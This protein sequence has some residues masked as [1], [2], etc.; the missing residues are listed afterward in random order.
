MKEQTSYS[1][2][3]KRAIVIL[4][5]LLLLLAFFGSFFFIRGRI[6]AN[7]ADQSGISDN[8]NGEINSDDNNNS[9]DNNTNTNGQ[10]PVVDTNQSSS[11]N[12]SE[13]IR[14]NNSNS[15]ANGNQNT[16]SNVV[17][18]DTTAPEI[19]GIENGKYYAGKVTATINADDLASAKCKFEAE[20]GT[21]TEF[22]FTTGH[23]FTESGKYTLTVKDESGKTTELTFTIDLNNPN[24]KINDTIYE[25]GTETIYANDTE[26]KIENTDKNADKA[27]LDDEELSDEIIELT[28]GTHT[29]KLTDKAG[30]ETVYTLVVDRTAPVLTWKDVEYTDGSTIYANETFVVNATDANEIAEVAPN[31]HIRYNGWRANGEGKYTIKVTDVAGNVATFTVIVDKTAPTLNLNGTS[32]TDSSKTIYS[33]ATEFTA[34]VEDVNADKVY[35]NDEEKTGTFTLEEGTYSVKVTDLAGNETVYTLVV[36]R[37]APVYTTLG[38]LNISNYNVDGK[39]IAYAKDGEKVRV[40]VSFAEKL[41]KEPIVQIGEKEYTATY[42][43]ASSNAD[44]NIYYYMAD[45]EVTTE[46][47]EG[48]LQFK[49]KDFADITGNVGEVL[50]NSN[51]NRSEYSKVIIDRTVPTLKLNGTNYTDSSKTIYSNATEFTAEVEDTNADKVYVN[52]EEK[53]GTFTLEE[54]TYSIK[55]TD[56]AGNENVYTLVVDRTNPTLKLNGTSYTDS[57]KTI[58]SNATEFTAEVEDVNADKV[59]VNDEEKT[60]PFT[61]EEGTYTVKVTDLAENETV[62]TLVVDRTAPVLTLCKFEKEYTGRTEL[63]TDKI[64]N[65]SLAVV[66]DEINLDTAK[67]EADDNTVVDYVSKTEIGARKDYTL[68]VTDL[69]GNVSTISFGID[70]DAP[71]IEGVENG[72]Y[73]NVDVAPVVTDK[74]LDKVT[75]TFNDAENDF[76]EGTVFTAEGKYTITAVDKAGNKTTKTFYIDKTAPVLEIK[77]DSIGTDPYY[78]RISFKLR[79]NMKFSNYYTINGTKMTVTPAQWGDADFTTLRSHLHQGENTIELIDMAGNKTTKTFVYDT[80][81]PVLT[82]CKFEKE[83]TGNTKIE[84]D[85]IYNYSVAVAIEEVNPYTAKLAGDDNSVVDYVS[86]TEIGARKDY[87]LTVTDLAGNVSTISF[88]ID[89]DAPKIESVEN[90]KYYNVDVAPVVTDK[91][92]NKVTYTFNG[93][94]NDFAEGTVFTAE[95]KYTITAT[96]LAG[97]STTKTFYIDKTAPVLE[98]KD[99]SIGEDPYYSRISFKLR[100]NMKFSNYYT[101]NGTKMTVSPAQYG[102]ADFTTLRSHLHQGENTIELVDMAGNKTTKTFV[103]DTVAPALTLYKFDDENTVLEAGKFYNHTVAVA[104]DEANPYTSELKADDNTV[105]DYTSKTEILGDKFYTLTVSDKAGN[106]SSIEFGVDTQ[107]PQINGVEDGK[108]Y[109]VDVTPEVTDTYLEKVTYTFNDG[110]EKD[111]TN[112][113]TFTAEGKYT[114]TA[115]DKVG[116]K[117]TKTFFIDKTAP[118]LEIKDDSIGTDPYYSRISFK[119]NDNMGFVKYILNGNVVEPTIAT[120]GDA[121]YVNIKD[122]LH[123]GENTMILVDQAGNETTKTFIYDT[124]AP[125]LTVKDDSIGI[126]PNYSKISFSLYD[127]KK[128]SNYYTINGTKMTVTPAQWGD[129][130][131]TTLRSHLNQ[132]ENTIELVDMAG[133]KA[134]KTFIYDTV[135]PTATVTYSNNNG[136]TLINQ[137]VTATL[138]A[139]EEIRD[140][141][142][143]TRVDEKTF[144]KVFDAN[145]KS[146]V[147]IVDLAGNK[148]SINYEVKRIDKIAPTITLN[149]NATEYVTLNE[150]Y[151]DAG[152]TVSD[153]VDKV[154]D[155]KQTVTITW[156]SQT[157]TVET[158]DA[159]DTSVEG[160]YTIEYKVTDKAGNTATVTRTVYVQR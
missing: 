52:D 110:T 39:N 21:T 140:L 14:R 63:E 138:T 73:Y 64:Y 69:A 45:I 114:I 141:D 91:H 13:N 36:D 105:V 5:L 135:A 70:K 26:F 107:A 12:Q 55:V 102:D 6:N 75:Y 106:S 11:T 43:E 108:Y 99:D 9:S 133:N 7:A 44:K 57:S 60:E 156:D 154:S 130:N 83:Y 79:D 16:A 29:I 98:I 31:G 67:L 95:G 65:Y 41:E 121:N 20:D 8:T 142:G 81:A 122:K 111:F 123:Q 54:G 125:T 128:F 112:G 146:S 46:M 74:H 115:V 132:G 68:T 42:R 80:V 84:A 23:K 86:K 101:I 78:S 139:S 82:L 77:A 119:L 3:R 34:E 134:T 97:N 51:I 4:I 37:T 24:L 35:V 143:W 150:S 33:N 28:E 126:D 136:Y 131:F 1:D 50:D 144:T 153:N 89:K 109:N 104:I 10:L 22:D 148:S 58:Y 47:P 160:I 2:K 155:L 92:L 48:E 40:L 32:Y 100:D 30:N 145:T 120:K 66:I 59:Y 113:T 17:E 94:E 56:L 124:V 76:A 19:T 96:D 116:N 18:P 38:I 147:E 71:K 72:K 157:G 93:A 127:N 137:D 61:L 118:V 85:K 151:T 129:A 158:V 159:V 103:Y 49:V 25:D 90:G 53:T 152:I 27:Y 117:T 15:R 87:T 88:G 149:G 62:Y